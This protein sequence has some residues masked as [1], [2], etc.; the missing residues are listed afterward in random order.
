VLR[1]ERYEPSGLGCSDA[2]ALRS[3]AGK[4]LGGKAIS[5]LP[6]VGGGVPDETEHTRIR[7]MMAVIDT[8]TGQRESFT[9]DPIDD[10]ATSSEHGRAASD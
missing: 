9:T 2:G 7:L 8:R 4:G 1:C 5:W 10:E 6:V 3:G